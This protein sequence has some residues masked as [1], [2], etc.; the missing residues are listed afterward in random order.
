MDKY[1]E[2]DSK[3]YYLIEDEFPSSECV[4]HQRSEIGI[5]SSKGSKNCVFGIEDFPHDSDVWFF[6]GH[7]KIKVEHPHQGTLLGLCEDGSDYGIKVDN[8]GFEDAILGIQ[9]SFPIFK[10]KTRYKDYPM[11]HRTIV[12]PNIIWDGHLEKLVLLEGRDKATLKFDGIFHYRT[13][14]EYV[15]GNDLIREDIY[16]TPKGLKED[17]LIT[18]HY[19]KYYYVSDVFCTNHPYKTE[20]KG[21]SFHNLMGFHNKGFFLKHGASID[22]NVWYGCKHC[23]DLNSVSEMMEAHFFHD[24]YV[25]QHFHT[26]I[27]LRSED[28]Y[29]DPIKPN[30]RRGIKPNPK[31]PKRYKQRRR[32]VKRVRSIKADV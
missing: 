8:Y 4:I 1:Y 25:E 19:S 13:I 7:E 23:K 24:S 28:P 3:R 30:Y 21:L 22:R 14:L 2:I 26:N 9:L 15:S 29:H 31:T 16:F 18:K 32:K 10:L 20:T 11:N 6:D 12:S 17:K 5:W 27:N